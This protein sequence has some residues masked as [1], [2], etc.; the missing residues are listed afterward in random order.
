MGGR[1]VPS[2]TSYFYFFTCCGGGTFFYWRYLKGAIAAK[3]ESLK[4]AEGAYDAGVI[5]DLIR[6]DAR[7]ARSKVAD[8]Q[9]RRSLGIFY[10]IFPTSTLESVQFTEFAYT[11]GR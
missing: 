9:A 11:L 6:L 1:P 4:R 2:C 3:D 5:Q 8:G 10:L 7:I